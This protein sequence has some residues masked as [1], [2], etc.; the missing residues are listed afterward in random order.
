ME[1]QT[2]TAEWLTLSLTFTSDLW[3]VTWVLISM[4]ADFSH[5]RVFKTLSS[6][7]K[8]VSIVFNLLQLFAISSSASGGD[9]IPLLPNF[10]TLLL[11][12][13][14]SNMMA[15][16]MISQVTLLVKSLLANAGDARDV[17]STP[18]SG[19]FP[20]GGN[21]NPLQYSSLEKSYRRR[22]LMGY[23]PG[24]CIEL[25][26]TELLSTC[27]LTRAHTHTHTHHLKINHRYS[28]FPRIKNKMVET[29]MILHDA[30][31]IY[32]GSAELW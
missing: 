30:E 10:R 8:A 24:G 20:G 21:G 27:M 29:E 15:L 3:L 13:Q 12:L 16:I 9:S 6:Y 17:S 4:D 25:D 1:S 18:G 14:L 31:T 22:R 2:D 11:F 32:F 26:M 23:S 7:A 19:R 28:H 5:V